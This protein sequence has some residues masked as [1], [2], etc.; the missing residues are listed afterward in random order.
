MFKG[1]YTARGA[2]HDLEVRARALM[3]ADPTAVVTGRSAWHLWFAD[4]PQPGS[5][6]AA[7]SRLRSRSGFRFEHRVVP[8]PL[9]VMRDEIRM[10]TRAL[11]AVE[12]ST[13]DSAFLDSALRG[14]VRLA[15]LWEAYRLTPQRPG[16]V[17]RR[18]LLI[19]S[20]D[21]PWSPAERRA[22]IA[23]RSA[24]IKGWKTN[25]GVRLR[26][27]GLAYLDIAFRKLRLAIE[28]DGWEFHSTRQAFARDR[29][30]DRQLDL[31]GWRVIR[32]TALEV[33]DHPN[34]FV[35]DVV[36]ALHRR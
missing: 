31:L 18:R 27:G 14:G 24:R 12:L 1:V 5:L 28:I 26:S 22:H 15:D 4:S 20:R 25:L 30:R 36:A 19:E 11:A 21:R 9:I 23:L 32:F 33:I 2:E 35:S 3:L 13:E 10:T 16:N 29:E 6:T 34:A 17:E 7:T 8:P